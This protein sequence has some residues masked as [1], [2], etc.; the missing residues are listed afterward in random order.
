MG[1]HILEQINGTPNDDE[2]L[3][4]TPDNETQGPMDDD[5]QEPIEL[6]DDEVLIG[7]IRGES[8]AAIFDP[9]YESPLTPEDFPLQVDTPLQINRLHRWKNSP[10]F[11]HGLS[12]WTIA[13]VAISMLDL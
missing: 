12:H 3:M 5:A 6:G 9:T 1:Y 4:N 10:H 7:Y 13:R 2:P 11:S 8:V